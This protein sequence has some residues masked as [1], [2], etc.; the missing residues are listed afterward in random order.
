M[1][2]KIFELAKELGVGAIDLVEKLKSNGF[3]VRNHMAMLTD[4]EV[5]KAM[6]IVQNEKEHT[7]VKGK[8][9]TTKKAKKKK[10]VSKASSKKTTKVI[11]TKEDLQ[12]ASKTKAKAKTK[13]ESTNK[14]VSVVRKK[15]VII[16]RKASDVEIKD[17]TLQVQ[18]PEAGEIN[19]QVGQVLVDETRAVQET[20]NPI[21]NK[22]AERKLESGLRIVSTPPASVVEE[23][24]VEVEKKEGVVETKDSSL[25]IYKEKIHTF[26]PVYIPPKVEKKEEEKPKSDEKEAGKTTAESTE[27]KDGKT[28]RKRMGG[29]ASIIS[30]KSKSNIN[31]SQTLSQERSEAELKSYATLSGTGKPLYTQVKRKKVYMGPSSRTS[32]TEIKQSKR[33]IYVHNG[34][35]ANVLANKLNVKFGELADKVMDFN[36]LVASE[37]Y[38][39]MILCQEIAEI[40]EYRVENKAFDENEVIEKANIS[41]DQRSK[42]P[43]RNPIITIMGHVDHGKTTLLDFIRNAKV[44]QGEAGGITQ[45]VGAYEVNVKGSTLTFLDTPGHAA[46]TTIRQ[47]GAQITDIVILI[48]AADDGIMPQTKESIKFCKDSNV[49]IIVAINK[50]DREGANAD[51]IKQELAE[52]ELTPEEWGGDTQCC[53]ISALKG[54]GID[55]LLEAVQLQAEMLELR[56]NPKGKAEGVVIES[57]VEQGR[58]PM[59]TILVQ[60][61]TLKKGDSVVVGES[62]GRARSL[63]DYAGKTINSAGPSKPVQILGLNQAPS[64]G[65]DVD[66]VKSEREAKKVVANRIQERK[67]AQ[68]QIQKKAVS[69]EDFFATFQDKAEF[70]ELKLIVR[71]DVQGSFEAIKNS[72]EALENAEVGV[73]V[74]AGGVG[75][76]TDSDVMLGAEASGYIIGFNMRPITSARRLAEQKGVDVKTYSIIYELIN[77]VK[78]A[79]EGLLEP[80]FEEKYIGRAEVKDTF[81]VPKIGLIA[82]SLVVDGKIQRGCSIRLLR[83]GK[84]VFDGKMS[85]LKR[86]KDDVKEVNNGYECGIGLDGFNDIKLKDM[87]EAYVKEEKKRKLEDIEINAPMV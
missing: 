75:A 30:G 65:D 73:K 23:E 38:I 52:F 47:R 17:E 35:T 82:G 36:L 85:S 56:E 67:E 48:V 79:L 26:T 78:L 31:K 12:A 6:E 87:F 55:Q 29:L 71:T 34:C 44:A 43:I 72:L 46:F 60:R 7:A 51:R 39:G 10:K 27:D 32:I 28:I 21:S 68:V 64:P 76:I 81:M 74:I 9:A 4:D 41:D 14:K 63:M 15:T 5:L 49:P 59:A 22:T 83:E 3:V 57:N 84:I 69:L 77:D 42:L 13:K 1:P 33:V 24:K 54:D 40:Y 11:T 58:G 45:H 80:N 20:E 2:K 8:K 18:V 50:M 66:V 37:D 53:A 16:R 86:F 61:G 25:K 19:E 70:K 62:Y